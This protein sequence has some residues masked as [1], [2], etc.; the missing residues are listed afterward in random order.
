MLAAAALDRAKVAATRG[1][2]RQSV[3][4]GELVGLRWGARRT[5][6]GPSEVA[7]RRR[8]SPCRPQ[9]EPAGRAAMWNERV[10]PRLQAFWPE[11]PARNTPAV[12]K[13]MVD[14]V[15][16]SGDAFPDAVDWALTYLQTMEGD[17]F[18]FRESGHGSRHPEATLRFLEAVV[19]P[20]GPALQHRHTL[21]QVLNRMREAMAELDVNQSFKTLRRN[22]VQLSRPPL[23]PHRV[24]RERVREPTRLQRTRMW[25][26]FPEM[27]PGGVARSRSR[28][29]AARS[30]PCGTGSLWRAYSASIRCPDRA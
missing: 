25:D 14:L 18:R 11:P 30:R 5:V 13:A 6:T 27:W 10:Q 1:R 7:T 29:S 24:R 22:A 2:P 17:I 19:P 4:L 26:P 28:T 8:R 15:A 9:G 3:S 23:P 12:S 20:E 16:E 21:G